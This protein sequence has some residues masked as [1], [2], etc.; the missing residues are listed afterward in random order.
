MYEVKRG[1][2]EN[3]Y[4]H[5]LRTCP[6]QPAI[7][8]DDRQ[9]NLKIE[10]ILK[11]HSKLKAEKKKEAA[12]FTCPYCGRFYKSENL[13]HLLGCAERNKGD[14]KKLQDFFAI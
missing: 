14:L 13:R 11:R 2:K 1:S 9:L 10:E 8:E 7:I 6:N 5:H 3:I 12:A 4:N